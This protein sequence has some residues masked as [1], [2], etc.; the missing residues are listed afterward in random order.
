MSLH[1][2]TVVFIGLLLVVSVMLA[3]MVMSGMFSPDPLVCERTGPA[4]AL[5]CEIGE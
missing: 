1:P 4:N 2:L 3:G 5:V